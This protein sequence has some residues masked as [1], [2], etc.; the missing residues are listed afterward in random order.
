MLLPLLLLIFMTLLL[1][2]SQ[3]VITIPIYYVLEHV[4]NES[5]YWNHLIA[6]STSKT[7]AVTNILGSL[8]QGKAG[9]TNETNSVNRNSLF[10]ILK[11]NGYSTGFYYGGNTNLKQLK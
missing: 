3:R 11:N 7:D 5:L 8:P 9:F 10:G 6:N 4:S 1:M 2:L